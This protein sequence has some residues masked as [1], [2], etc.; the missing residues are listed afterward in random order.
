[1]NRLLPGL[2]LAISLTILVVGLVLLGIFINGSSPE[3]SQ[4][5]VDITNPYIAGADWNNMSLSQ[6]ES[7]VD[8]ALDAMMMGGELTESERQS[9]IYY[10]EKLDNVFYDPTNETNLVAWELTAFTSSPVT[11]AE[12]NWVLMDSGISE[13]HLRGVSG[14]SFSDVFAVGG[15]GTMIHFDGNIWKT[16]DSGTTNTFQGIH[17]STSGLVAGGYEGT[18]V[19]YN[20]GIWE[21]IESG[22][23][24]HM[25]DVGGTPN[26]TYI[27]GTA[28]TVLYYDGYRCKLIDT[29]AT[30]HLYD[31]WGSS[32]RD[33][34]IV[35]KFGTILNYD[36][37]S[38]K[39]MESGTTNPLHG[40]WGTSPTNVFAVSSQ[41]L[42]IHYDGQSWQPMESNTSVTLRDVWGRSSN[43]VYVVGHEGTI[44]HYDGNDWIPMISAKEAVSSLPADNQ[45]LDNLWGNDSDIFVVGNYGTILYSGEH[46]ITPK[47]PDV[48]TETPDVPTEAPP[49]YVSDFLITASPYQV[50]ITNNSQRTVQVLESYIGYRCYQYIYYNAPGGGTQYGPIVSTSQIFEESAI[51]Q[52][53]K[54]YSRT[55]NRQDIVAITYC[56]FTV[57]DVNTGRTVEVTYG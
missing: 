39:S 57:K 33:V 14:T 31:V 55:F 8:T 19:I 3:S 53:G 17:M 6:K 41:G 36:G 22:V 11:E 2:V 46:Q 15:S 23:E 32:S 42:I 50:T 54:S 35:G 10:I 38:W 43:D 28:G 25:Y 52:P 27:V 45:D 7:W 49:I 56:R 24:N 13:Y 47:T 5:E 18:V 44:L 30:A 48:P 1:M 21:Q 37:N 51:L 34:F 16:V 4:P 26:E 29:G 9:T 40:V 20:Q 12:D